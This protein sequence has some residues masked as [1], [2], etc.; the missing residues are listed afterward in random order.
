MPKIGG[1]RKKTKTQKE[2]D[3]ESEDI[4]KIPK[5]IINILKAII[6]KRGKLNKPWK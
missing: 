3:E 4:I 5:S 2:S 1:K 6:I